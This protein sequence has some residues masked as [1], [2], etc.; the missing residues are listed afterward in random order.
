MMFLWGF[1][2]DLN[3]ALKANRGENGAPHPGIQ[4][5]LLSL[6][7]LRTFSWKARVTRT[8]TLSVAP[9]RTWKRPRASNRK[10]RPR[11]LLVRAR[12]GARPVARHLLARRGRARPEL[13]ATAAPPPLPT[14]ARLGGNAGGLLL[15]PDP[16]VIPSDWFGRHPVAVSRRSRA[17]AVSVT[18]GNSLTH[19]RDRLSLSRA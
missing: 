18:P 7:C 10:P 9:T 13:T 6:P 19:A 3:T 16:R 15:P 4:E 12:H 11:R 1:S 17:R 8:C 2:V 5:R 14:A